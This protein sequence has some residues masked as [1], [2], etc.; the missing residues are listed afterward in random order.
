MQAFNAACSYLHRKTREVLFNIPEE[1]KEKTMEIVLRSQ[2]SLYLI[3]TDGIRFVDNQGTCFRCNPKNAYQVSFYEIREAVLRACG[4]ALYAHKDEI[5]NGYIS[6]GN[7]CRMAITGKLGTVHDAP[8]DLSSVTAVRLR[9]GR[10]LK[11]NTDFLFS[12]DKLLSALLVGP[13]ASGKTTILRSI[14]M[15]LS[16]GTCGDFYRV[17]VIDERNEIFPDGLIQAACVDVISGLKKE[18]G[19]NTALRLCSPQV[20]ICDEIGTLS[21]AKAILDSLNSG[22]KFICSMHAGN[23]SEL[24][25]R[26]CFS[27]LYEKKVFERLVFLDSFSLPGRITEYIDTAEM[28][29]CKV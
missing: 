11:T 14:A 22:V 26:N 24:F 15:N 8:A 25:Q 19:I 20:I 4:Y 12:S 29:S 9:I 28:K 1:L 27:C 18:S 3:C 5:I 13:P 6:L 16:N 17:A 10:Y 7:G 21:E 23:R 2:Q